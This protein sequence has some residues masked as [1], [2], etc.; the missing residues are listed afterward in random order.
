M[1]V[2]ELVRCARCGNTNPP[3]YRY[4]GN[5]GALVSDHE[6][7]EN[8]RDAGD[9][10]RKETRV[11]PAQRPISGPSFLG[12][13]TDSP[14]ESGDGSH[15]VGYLLEDDEPKSGAGRFLL[16]LVIIGVLGAVG[17]LK[18][19]GVGKTWLPPWEKG[20]SQA[21]NAA[22]EPN[23]TSTQAAS[24]Q[25]QSQ[26]PADQANVKP[27]APDAAASAPPAG[28]DSSSKAAEDKP[29]E[30]A[31]AAQPSAQDNAASTAKPA[32]SEPP[33]APAHHPAATVIASS[34]TPPPAKASRKDD[35]EDSVPAVAKPSRTQTKSRASAADQT[36]DD[37]LVSNAE[38]YL[39]G[40]G[41]PQ[42]CA[43]A[44]SGL[45]AAADRQN[46]RARSLLGTMYATGHC[47]SRDLPTAYRWFALA[48]RESSDNVWI[49]R[50]L[51]LIWREMTPQERKLAT[52]RSE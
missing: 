27:P 36:P 25:A 5:C 6:G 37:A 14:S 15:D 12:L 43:R 2:G 19:S 21:Q 29:Q 51:E 32:R 40:R 13:G 34:K 39:Y 41:A 45:R 4:C 17:W 31:P 1:S 22:S 16:L 50:N 10:R 33:P 18:F 24:P 46:A 49:Q 11:L 9:I 7:A 35:V 28:A 48:S 26:P 3:E 23:S 47:V 52:A 38:K 42:N 30:T 20:G 44:L 8:A